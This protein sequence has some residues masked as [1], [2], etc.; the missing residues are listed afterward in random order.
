MVIPC[1]LHTGIIAPQ[2]GVVSRKKFLNENPLMLSERSIRGSRNEHE[3][4]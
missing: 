1:F 4:L 3:E 2:P